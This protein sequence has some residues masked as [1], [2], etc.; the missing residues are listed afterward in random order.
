MHALSKLCRGCCVIK[1]VSA[2]ELPCA[3]RRGNGK[4]DIF[5]PL[6]THWAKARQAAFC[7]QV[8]YK[9]SLKATIL[10]TIDMTLRY[11]LLRQLNR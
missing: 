1:N 5:R 6:T 2:T 4:G 11:E 10:K 3:I 8:R 7:A 9:K